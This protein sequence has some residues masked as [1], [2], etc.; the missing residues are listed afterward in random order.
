M[1]VSQSL[2]GQLYVV[3][4]FIFY[5]KIPSELASFMSLEIK[6]HILGASEDILSI[7]K[8]TVQFLRLC[9]FGSFLK[10]YL[11]CIKWK[12]SFIVSGPESFCVL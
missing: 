8:Y 4:N 2:Q 12:L 3:Q 1:Y 11:F 7:S 6:F 5:L 9:S 10:L